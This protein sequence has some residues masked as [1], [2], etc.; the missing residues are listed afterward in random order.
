VNTSLIKRV[1]I[2]SIGG[3]LEMYDF[4][5]YVF[6]A[7]ILGKLFFPHDSQFISLLSVYGIFTI[8]YL[9]RPIGGILFGHYGDKKGRKNGLLLSIALMGFST[10]FIGILPTYQQIGITAPILLIVFRII[11][12]LAVGGDLPGAI[13]YISETSPSANKGLNCAWVFCGV[14]V[15]ILVASGIAATISILLS[16]EQLT[17][18]GWR[19]AFL[20]ALILIIVGYFLRR[21]LDESQDFINL[22]RKIIKKSTPLLSLL[23]T[24]EFFNILRGLGVTWLFAVIIAQCYLYMPH[25]LVISHSLQLSHALWLNSLALIIFSFFIPIM[26]HLSDKIGRKKILSIASLL[27]I[28]TTYPIYHM[29][30]H[31]FVIYGVIIMAIIT[32]TFI[33]PSIIFLAGLFTTESRF[34]GVGVSYNVG[35]AIFGGLTPIAA[36]IILH[37]SHDSRSISYN[38]II[39]ALVALV[40]IRST[41]KSKT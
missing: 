1:S 35:F 17:V 22:P 36:T 33:G 8:G 24:R 41:P 20:L 39:A 11:Q 13:T 14:N 18:W 27:I 3:G 10:L 6:F 23:T 28:V 21:D 29:L 32:A 7:P 30:T 40:A 25:F 2:T 5:I 12:G 9:S 19:L 38:L 4:V 34:T 16:T 26:G 37:Y 15:G 31:G